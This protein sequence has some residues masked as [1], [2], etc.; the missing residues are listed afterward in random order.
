M[1]RTSHSGA[2]GAGGA[3]ADYLGSIKRRAGL[4][5]LLRALLACS[6]L[7]SVLLLAL[8]TMAPAVVTPGYA[9]L[10][11]LLCGAAALGAALWLLRPLS[12]LRGYG[13]CQLVAAHRPS[14]ASA[15]QSALE[16]ATRGPG[17]GSPALVGA[18]AASVRAALSEL[19]P[20][21]VVPWRGLLQPAALAG[22]AALLL[23]LASLGA[24]AS[25]RESL[26]ALLSPAQ[27]RADGVH[28][29]PVVS[30]LQARLIYPSYLQRKAQR[31]DDPERIEVPRGTTIELNLQARIAADFGVVVL[32]ESRVQ[33]RA[34]GERGQHRYQARIEAREDS[35]LAIRFESQGRW[36]QDSR[37]RSLSVVADK[38]PTIAIDAPRDGMIVEAELPLSIRYRAHDDHG[39]ATLELAVRLPD[40][41]E[42]RRRLWAALAADGP[43]TQLD[44][45]HELLPSEL[46][47]RPGDLLL[48]WLEATDADS[49]AGPNLGTSPTLALEIASE[50]QR[51][52]LH[53]PK[54]RQLLDGA[55]DVLADRLEQPP[56]EDAMAARKRMAE[57]HVGELAFT[58]A[59]SSVIDSVDA[60]PATAPIDTEQLRG[61]RN[62]IRRAL[63]REDSLHQGSASSHPLRVRL[64]GE[65]V[66][67]EEEAVILLADAVAEA[68]VNEARQL[69]TELGELQE[70]IE[71]L[72]ER[73]K[74]EP[75]AEGKRALLA[76]IAKAQ[77]RLREL[78]QN[79]SR[80]AKRVPSEFINQEAI[81]Q[82]N[83]RSSIEELRN[84][85]EGDDLARAEEAL[86]A[87]QE[88]IEELQSQI[89]GGGAR[90]REAHFGPR[91]RAL[92][93]ARRELGMI[94]EQQQRLAERSS[95]IV[96][97]ATGRVKGQG[98]TST[99]SMR[100]RAAAL[101]R[102]L[103]A[104]QKDA[105]GGMES[106]LLGRARD[107]LR[108]ARDA[109]QTGDLAQASRNGRA[110]E[111]HLDHAAASMNAEAQMF[112]GHKGETWE[113]AER[114]QRASQGLQ[115]LNQELDRATPQLG[116]HLSEGQRARMRGDATSQKET[117]GAAERLRQS[118]AH[119]P[120]NRPLSPQAEQAMGEVSDAMQAAERALKQGKPQQAMQAQQEASDR[121][122]EIDERLA[123][124]QQ[125]GSGSQSGEGREGEGRDGQVDG[126]VE[127]P[128]A[129]A[130]SGPVEMRRKLL[131]A[132]REPGPR[133][134]QGAI[135]RYYEELLR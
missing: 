125:A 132:M 126:P 128:D 68:L 75:S 99:E 5:L 11:L 55:L 1:N 24:S 6:G 62:R 67:E 29:A 66:E 70:E 15:L 84:A 131:D 135:R 43:R 133:G 2:Q 116:D 83:A 78:A 80:L 14:L 109:L 88:Q 54:L 91:D 63:R 65:V 42:E 130:F 76:E 113:R 16:L 98:A 123:Q 104:L 57:L 95:D 3:I 4:Q 12:R 85:V 20:E 32:G 30:S 86:A 101:E 38:P 17:H 90:F 114:A 110:A 25:L 119:G 61:A 34:L 118:L 134:F 120:D 40:G 31:L 21:R 82:S 129:E 112:P 53:V 96:R 122:R 77:R 102:Q 19:P 50:A 92:A 18:H 94:G 47:A 52:S 45:S 44:D 106:T 103:E 22:A 117:R 74:N 36:Y 107:R 69:S 37:A 115:A 121:I 87:L 93:E 48:L 111:R 64:D 9:R 60:A 10:S 51:L 73:F 81:P 28:L 46:G 71:K 108:D 33:L 41:S 59:L 35:E 127:I 105:P 72:L 23:S 79:L 8:A 39:L 100:E 27:V 89:E 7:A 13:G 124:R 26:G 58:E 97:D 56:P 49:V